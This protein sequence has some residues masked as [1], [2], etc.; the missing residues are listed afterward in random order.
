MHPALSQSIIALAALSVLA[1]AAAALSRRRRRA[2]SALDRPWPLEPERTL[3]SETELVLYRRLVQAA[4]KHI[5][6]SQVQLQQMVRLRAGARGALRNHFNQLSVDF[7]IVRPDT[8]IVA[9]IELDDASHF[10]EPRRRADARKT[11]ALRSAGIPLLRWNVRQL[12]SVRA[13]QAA[14]VDRLGEE[15]PA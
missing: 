11:H 15:R 2:S 1:A 3:L 6:L 4:P 10:R 5:V 14:L 12:P 7:V 8:S 9:A 13:I